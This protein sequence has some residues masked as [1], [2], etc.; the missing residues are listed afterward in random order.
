[1]GSQLAC[2]AGRAYMHGRQP[3]PGINVA[4]LRLPTLLVW[5]RLTALLPLLHRW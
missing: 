2:R 3:P 4:E 5:C 1:M